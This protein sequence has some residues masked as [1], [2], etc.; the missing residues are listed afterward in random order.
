MPDYDDI[1]APPEDAKPFDPRGFDRPEEFAREFYNLKH[2]QIGSILRRLEALEEG[3]ATAKLREEL[4]ATD[5][6]LAQHHRLLQPVLQATGNQPGPLNGNVL[7]TRAE[8]DAA[9]LRV[10]G[11]QRAE[12]TDAIAKLRAAR[13]VPRSLLQ[14][15]RDAVRGFVDPTLGGK[16]EVR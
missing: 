8:L 5:A 13:V 11:A 15:L 9:L 12:Y 2:V 1:S 14:R 7:I 10:S 3:E 4:A 6:V 16:L